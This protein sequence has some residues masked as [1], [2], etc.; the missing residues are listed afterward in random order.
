MRYKF[1]V[2]L[3]AVVYAPLQAQ[4]NSAL[5]YSFVQDLIKHRQYPYVSNELKLA[6]DSNQMDDYRFLYL[7]WQLR[8]RQLK[9]ADTSIIFDKQKYNL[10]WR[11][12]IGADSSLGGNSIHN[13]VVKL[14]FLRHWDSNFILTRR[15]LK[16]SFSD[17]KYLDTFNIFNN[18]ELVKTKKIINARV[19][20]ATTL[21]L[22]PGAGKWYLGRKRDALA[23]LFNVLMLGGAAAAVHQALPKHPVAYGFAALAAGFYVGGIVSTPNTLRTNRKHATNKIRQDYWVSINRE[24][25]RNQLFDQDPGI[26]LSKS[27]DSLLYWYKKSFYSTDL[28]TKQNAHHQLVMNAINTKNLQ[29]AVPKWRS[30]FFRYSADTARVWQQSKS[31]LKHLFSIADY[32]SIDLALYEMKQANFNPQKLAFWQFASNYYQNNYSLCIQQLQAGALP[33]TDSAQLHTLLKK[34]HKRKRNPKL[35][36]RL[37]LLPGMGSLYCGD[38][39][40]AI[41]SMAVIGG[42][43]Y[44]TFW[45]IQNTHPL[46]GVPVMLFGSRYYLGGIHNAAIYAQKRNKKNAIK[47]QKR[48]LSLVVQ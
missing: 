8:T 2:L 20:I 11:K 32:R 24:F 15:L 28:E 27:P 38:V 40:N 29:L 43:G 25:A 13:A 26:V 7:Q 5:H 3:F 16:D 30:Y 33:C 23:S 31:I 47:F 6:A 41:N 46:V 10:I 17:L 36:S 1:V 34:L 18:N 45:L 44:A 9:L 4:F 42:F 37:S 35:A 22:V 19:G 39:K 48:V 21:S 12:L 14:N